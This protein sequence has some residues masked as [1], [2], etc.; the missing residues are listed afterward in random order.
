[1]AT[2]AHGKQMDKFIWQRRQ[3]LYLGLGMVGVGAASA[4]GAN[5]NKG[6]LGAAHQIDAANAKAM[7]AA[8]ST[9]MLALQS[10]GNSVPKFQAK[11]KG[12]PIGTPDLITELELAVD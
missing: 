7:M 4:F 12:A 11:S 6:S 9:Q 10:T 8:D 3:I 2:K 5:A 1:V